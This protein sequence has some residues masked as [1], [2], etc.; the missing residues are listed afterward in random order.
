MSGLWF[1][2]WVICGL[3]CLHLDFSVFSD[4]FVHSF[5]HSANIY[6]API[7]QWWGLSSDPGRPCLLV[8]SERSLTVA[9]CCLRGKTDVVE[10]NSPWGSGR[11]P[12]ETR[13]WEVSRT[14]PDRE[15]SV[16]G[17]ATEMRGC[18]RSLE[19]CRWILDGWSSVFWIGN[20]SGEGVIVLKCSKIRQKT[21]RIN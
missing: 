14:K 17:R 2:F 6:W 20:E 16:S 1:S 5:V 19:N 7:M 3:F 13:T 18:V 4:C 12:W 21:K 11:T 8:C 10:W 9:T 15:G